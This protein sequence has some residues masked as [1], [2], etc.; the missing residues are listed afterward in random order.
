MGNTQLLGEKLSYLFDVFKNIENTFVEI[1]PLIVGTPLFTNETKNQLKKARMGIFDAA[2]EIEAFD[3]TCY[4]MLTAHKISQLEKEY[5]IKVNE[6]KKQKEINM[7]LNAEK[8]N[9]PK[10]HNNLEKYLKTLTNKKEIKELLLSPKYLLLNEREFGVL[11][12]YYVDN[13]TL[14]AIAKEYGRSPSRIFA[15]KQSGLH[16]LMGLKRPDKEAQLFL[17]EAKEH[18]LLEAI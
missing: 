9:Q 12:K 6:L 8:E 15:N 3:R 16:K 13:M 5:L 14:G 7:R 1:E 2:K 10:A 4:G 18:K 17:K 11:H